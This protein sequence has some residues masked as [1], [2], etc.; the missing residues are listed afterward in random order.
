MQSKTDAERIM[1]IGADKHKVDVMGNFKF[2]ISLDVSNSLR[3]LE[4]IKGRTLLAASTIKA[5]KK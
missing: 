2:D 5:K 4:N 3:W 1:A